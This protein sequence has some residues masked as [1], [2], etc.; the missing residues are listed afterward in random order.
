MTDPL[1][2]YLLI[3]KQKT[4]NSL[5]ISAL[6]CPGESCWVI[7]NVDS[8]LLYITSCFFLFSFHTQCYLWDMGTSTAALGNLQLSHLLSVL[9]TTR[10]PA[11]G[12]L[13]G[14]FGDFIQHKL[15]Q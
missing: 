12:Q 5:L 3:Q 14:P 10:Y 1:F 2:I 6:F 7:E 4:A 15:L 13:S 9:L 11:R 8:A